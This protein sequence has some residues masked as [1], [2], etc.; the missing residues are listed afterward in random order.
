[1]KKVSLKNDFHN[2]EVTVAGENPYYNC[3]RLTPR[4]VQ[5]AKKALCGIEGC[6][7]SNDLGVRGDNQGME[8]DFNPNGTVDVY[9]PFEN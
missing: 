7:C 6:T 4:S 1:M 2:T 5:K 8:F 9:V 3:I